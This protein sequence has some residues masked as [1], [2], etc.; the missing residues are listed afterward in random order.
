MDILSAFITQKLSSRRQIGMIIPDVVTSEVH[1]D[2][3]TITD[4]PVENLS[5]AGGV[6]SNIA[7]HAYKNPAQ[8]VM[9]IGFASGG[10]L[11]D[12]FDTSSF[13]E[14]LGLSP[15]EAYRKLIE[16]QN[17]RIPFDVTTG[18]RQYSNMLISNITA[19]TDTASENVLNCEVTL[20]EVIFSQTRRIDVAEKS[21]MKTG[22]STSSVN[23]AGTKTLKPADRSY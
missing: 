1:T 22:V 23:T 10:S 7:D 16:L 12:F 8:V 18:K 9:K 13:I 15:K 19:T 3:L 5:V 21:E 4:H 14:P 11:V 17:S 20:R 6:Y 2:A